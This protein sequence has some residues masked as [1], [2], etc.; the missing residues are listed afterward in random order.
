MEP[1]IQACDVCGVKYQH[2]PHRYE[3]HWLSLY[4]IMCCDSC[5]KGNWDGWTPHY[6]DK[7]LEHAKRNGLPVPPRNEKGRLPRN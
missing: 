2:G 1:I 6:E 4:G 3:G 5:W 7:L